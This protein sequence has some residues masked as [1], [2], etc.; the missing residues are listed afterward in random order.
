M[1]S[2]EFP[3]GR[4]SKLHAGINRHLDAPPNT[5]ISRCQRFLPMWGTPQLGV[6][7]RHAVS[8]E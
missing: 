7:C 8:S 6:R 2:S 4:C 1:V 5:Y 3:R